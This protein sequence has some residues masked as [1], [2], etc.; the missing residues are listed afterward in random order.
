MMFAALARGV[1]RTTLLAHT[2][3][4]TLVMHRSTPAFGARLSRPCTPWTAVRTYADAGNGPR[5]DRY[6]F[7]TDNKEWTDEYEKKRTGL[8]HDDPEWLGP[9]KDSPDIQAQHKNPYI[10]DDRQ[11]RRNFGDPISENDDINS[12]WMVDA[13]AN[14]V[15]DRLLTTSYMLKSFTLAW[16]A[17]GAVF[18][19]ISYVAKAYRPKPTIDRTLPYENGRAARG[20]HVGESWSRTIDKDRDLHTI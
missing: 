7:P 13:P 2:R 3:A 5:G 4:S 20:L 14:P 1:G 6:H 18:L 16:L 12:V 17:V 8:V 19:G 10:Y 9:W 11:D 15:M